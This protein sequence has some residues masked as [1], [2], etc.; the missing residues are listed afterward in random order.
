[1]STTDVTSSGGVV[2][3]RRRA[4]RESIGEEADGAADPITAFAH[5]A[6]QRAEGVCWIRADGTLDDLFDTV[7]RTL[8]ELGRSGVRWSGGGVLGDS[9][10]EWFAFEAAGAAALVFVMSEAPRLATRQLGVLSALSQHAAYVVAGGAVPPRL[11]RDL[12]GLT[13]VPV[14]H[15]AGLA[16]LAPGASAPAR[17]AA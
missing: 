1:M 14:W 12:A 4:Q 6:V 5:W 8:P 10:G 11:R 13:G 7:A 17:L 3:G 2:F 9:G 16:R 15:I